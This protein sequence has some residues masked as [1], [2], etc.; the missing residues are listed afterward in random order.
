M[1]TRTMRL[2][3]IAL[4]IATQACGGGAN[5]PNFQATIAAAVQDTQTAA[6]GN[7]A[8]VETPDTS[9]NQVASTPTALLSSGQATATPGGNETN[10]DVAPPGE[11]FFLVDNG[12]VVELI[13]APWCFTVFGT[14][15]VVCSDAELA[16]FEMAAL[17]APST[18]NSAPVVLIKSSTVSLSALYLTRYMAGIGAALDVDKSGYLRVTQVAPGSGASEAGLQAGDIILA[19]D[20]QALDGQAL[21]QREQ[22]V[23]TDGIINELPIRGELYSQVELQI[24]RGTS[25]VSVT[26]IRKTFVKVDPVD[27]TYAPKGDYVQVIPNSPL[28]PGY[29][30]I[31]NIVNLKVEGCFAIHQPGVQIIQPGTTSLVPTRTPPAPAP[32]LTPTLIPTLMGTPSCLDFTPPSDVP[33][34]EISGVLMKDFYQWSG[35]VTDYQVSICGEPVSGGDI[36]ISYQPPD[37]FLVTILGSPFEEYKRKAEEIFHKVLGI[38]QADACRLNVTIGTPYFANPNESGKEYHLSYC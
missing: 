7:T 38:S 29:Y 1:T 5:Q 26:V 14:T 25:T 13:S 10:L 27:V 30:C 2:A 12:A 18:T 15:R 36:A 11:G 23:G 17:K 3:V 37:Y 20:G 35:Y 16:E 32:T 6:G 22:I 31:V 33:W 24:L 28:R 8:P 21:K 34:R 9:T 19:I 4:I